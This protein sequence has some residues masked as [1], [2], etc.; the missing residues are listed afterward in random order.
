MSEWPDRDT[1]RPG[2]TPWPDLDETDHRIIAALQRDGRASIAKLAR[3]TALPPAR[4]KARYE[5]LVERGLI[6]T[7]A[8]I[9]PS[10]LGRPVVAHIEIAAE[11]GNS[12]L[13]TRLA[14][15]P[16]VAWIGV[17]DDYERLLVQVSTSSNAGLVDLVNGVVRSEPE[18]AS[19]STSIVLR[20]WSPVFAF[21]GARRDEPPLDELLWR[22][23]DQSDRALDDVDRMLLAMLERDARVSL[24]A[25]S[26]AS[27]LSV[28]A[29]RQRVMRLTGDHTIQIR[30]RPDARA[31]GVTAVRL[32]M[33][34]KGDSTSI[35]RSLAG[36]PNVN[37]ISEST[38]HRPL[39]VEL[40]CAN[41]AQIGEGFDAVSHIAGVRSA[42]MMRFRTALF[43]T[44]NW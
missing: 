8:L 38:G 12:D 31:P 1:A 16:G 30:T 43:Q 36:M 29:T 14:Q 4:V 2:P 39:S 10:I 41:E 25:M 17:A 27:G 37:F 33:E 21:T 23:G 22:T 40:L 35:V 13:A 32:L 34:T 9:D 24:T 5:R 44:G 28:P 15:V 6:R 18:I 7:V 20:S 42:H 26:A 3:D 19:L 11:R